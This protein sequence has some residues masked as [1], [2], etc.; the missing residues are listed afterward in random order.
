MN[1]STDQELVDQQGDSSDEGLLKGL[2]VATGNTAP[3][4]PR[5][6]QDSEYDA[7]FVSLV[8]DL[9]E[10]DRRPMLVMQKNPGGVD[11]KDAPVLRYGWHTTGRNKTQLIS[12][13]REKL[14]YEP[15]MFSDP[16]MLHEMRTFQEVYNMETRKS[17]FEAAG[18][19]TTTSS[20]PPHSP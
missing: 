7:S 16:L 18:S 19:I 10:T 8:E 20:S 12:L 11:V 2:R 6:I 17:K 13:L 14:E 4:G 9:M 5:P 1:L 15:G 3:S